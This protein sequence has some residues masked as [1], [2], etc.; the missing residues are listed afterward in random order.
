VL[1][2]STGESS[3]FYYGNLGV[4]LLKQARRVVFDF[5]KMTLTLQ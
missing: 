3:K 5:K 1:L 2:T 4:D